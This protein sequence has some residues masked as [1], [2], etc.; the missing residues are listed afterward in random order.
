MIHR[1]GQ[2]K[3][4]TTH[5]SLGLLLIAALSLLGTIYFASQ[6]APPSTHAAANDML[7]RSKQ[8]SVYSEKLQRLLDDNKRLRSQ[9]QTMQRDID[10]QP[11]LKDA[12]S[13]SCD[14]LFDRL[15]HNQTQGLSDDSIRRSRANY[16][17]VYRLDQV[18]Q[19]LMQ[20]RRPLHVV[21]FGGSITAAHGVVRNLS[22]V[23]SDSYT[24]LLEQWFNQQ[25]PVHEASRQQ[26]ATSTTNKQQHRV[27]NMA[28]HGAD[29]C[30]LAKRMTSLLAYLN[31]TQGME[32]P[33]MILLEY[34]VNDYQGQD[35]VHHAVSRL[36]VFFQGF[37]DIALCAEVVV[38]KLLTTYPKAAVVFVEFRT[39]I[40]ERKTAQ[41]LHAGVAQ[42]YQIPVISYSDAIFPEFF[43]LVYDKLNASDL[44][45]VPIGETILPF[46]H[47]CHECQPETIV[48]QFR[49]SFNPQGL[50]H[51]RTVCDIMMY[52]GLPCDHLAPPPPGR[53]Y[54]HP[55][56]FAVDA[57]HPSAMGHQ[58]A[59]DLIVHALAT[60]IRGQCRQRQGQAL[61]I[62]P[63]V[64]APVGWLGTPMALQ[65]RSNFV[66]VHDADCLAPFCHELRPSFKSPG[67]SLYSD[68]KGFDKLGWIAT[69]SS[70]GEVLEFTIDLP[71]RPCYVVYLAILRS[72]WEGMG[73]MQVTVIDSESGSETSAELD[74]LWESKISVWS[75]NQITSDEVPA[76]T[77]RCLVRVRTLPQV[78]G[79][80][81]N[82]AKILTLSVRECIK[83][84]E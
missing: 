70:G 57:V 52:A 16:G 3:L 47:G 76:C 56:I 29:M 78:D 83:Q 34:A 38:Y 51:C 4:S 79:R 7:D 21:A 20:Q 45:T 18:A 65:S 33:D 37:Q 74:S 72:Y 40:L 84:D 11:A 22:H 59:K 8:A 77:G 61:P 17:H 63:Q 53:A 35:H 54:C 2:I 23:G 12:D 71:N 42:S 75:D 46:P 60:A 69:N 32:Q 15:V 27:Y 44:Y 81:G 64:L 58:I 55:A 5:L 41:M 39:G 1:L 73:K 24:G 50:K 28:Q 36:D 80:D 31:R 10:V 48:D 43:E 26:S 82:K 62:R 30:S 6:L 9:L 14:T 49:Y 25:F 68:S 19:I 67:F 13:D 66:L